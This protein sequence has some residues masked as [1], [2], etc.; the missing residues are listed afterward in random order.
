MSLD[1]APAYKSTGLEEAEDGPDRRHSRHGRVGHRRR[2][3]LALFLVLAATVS[4]IGLKR[5]HSQSL[6][7]DRD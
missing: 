2:H 5:H 4:L 1:Q 6:A 7:D 3:R